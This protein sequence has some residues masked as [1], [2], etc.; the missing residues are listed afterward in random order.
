MG[1]PGAGCEAEVVR[2]DAGGRRLPGGSPALLLPPPPLSVRAEQRRRRRRPVWRGTA[3]P[4]LMGDSVFSE[5]PALRYAVSARG[6]WGGKGL[7][8][9]AVG[10]GSR[11]V[12]S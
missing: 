1:Q 10:R 11:P 7:R 5:K 9:A 3:P 12:G 2:R 6:R 4:A 8:G